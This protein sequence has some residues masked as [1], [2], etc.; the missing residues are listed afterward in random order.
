MEQYNNTIQKTINFDYAIKEKTK[1]HIL[2]WP[3]I[4]GYP[5]RILIIRGSGSRKTNS[6]FNLIIQQPDMD[7]IHLYSKDLNEAKYQ[8]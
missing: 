5:C 3:E 6:L 2:Y 4:P 1:E 8:F 7:K